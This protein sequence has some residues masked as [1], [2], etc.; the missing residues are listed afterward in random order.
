MSKNSSLEKDE[1]GN[2][3]GAYTALLSVDLAALGDNYVRLKS[4]ASGAECAAVVKANAYG[5]GAQQVGACLYAK[6]CRT[7]FVATPAEGVQLRERLAD[8]KIYIL[9]GYFAASSASY[10]QH[11]LSPVLGSLSAIKQWA[12]LCSPLTATPSS[13][14][15]V[16]TGMNRLGIGPDEFEEL[17]SQQGPLLEPINPDLIM[18]HLACA[19]DPKHPR[20]EHQRK[21]FK[22]T[23]SHLAAN[24]LS[25]ANS[26]GIFL[27]P[28]FHFDLVRPG[29]ALYG[30]RSAI[31][32]DISMGSVVSLTSKI[33]Q[34]RTVEK[35]DSIGYGASFVVS[36]KT[37]LATV[38]I[39]YADG[40][41]RA[42]GSSND[43]KGASAYI[44]EYEAPLLGRVSM[45]LI[46]VD[47]TD[48]PA[49]AA[50]LG[51]D[52]ELLGRHV[53]IDDLADIGGTIGY[54]ILTSLGM[55]ARTRVGRKT[56]NEV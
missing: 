28:D 36:R 43:R 7:F 1:S 22:D 10:L 23:V 13:A 26:A 52:V 9:D 16:D 21:L 15:H 19:D 49:N 37:R 5:T 39:G 55:A 54:E 25:L 8:V 35:G 40:Y 38:P 6:G 47:I 50:E 2:N 24:R 42:L 20:N 34:I 27:G 4:L 33:A 51:T 46:T 3:R 11:N 18:S 14:I 17:I 12:L 56:I 53:S 48:I 44:G 29:I 45:D 30:G 31:G 41:H 32:S